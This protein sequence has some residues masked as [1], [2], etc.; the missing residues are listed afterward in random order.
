MEINTF[1]SIFFYYFYIIIFVCFY[2][3]V[4]VCAL[5]FILFYFIFSDR[6]YISQQPLQV[7]PPL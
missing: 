2:C 4:F 5:D 1:G 7:A 3:N 6:S